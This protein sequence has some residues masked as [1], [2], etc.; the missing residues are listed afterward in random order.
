MNSDLWNTAIGA[1]V[2]VSLV[3]VGAWENGRRTRK[4]EAR[5]EASKERE[6]LEAQADELV[7]AVL[8][9]RVAGNA[10]DHLWGGWAARAR[11]GF[12]AAVQGGAAYARS[13]R[14]GMP[15]W[16]AAYGETANAI[17]QWDRES[18][19]S[20]AGLAAP[21]SRLGAAVAPLL[22]RQEPGL[23]AAAEA[24]FTTAMERHG[25][26]DRMTQA[27]EAFHAALR[28]ALEP[29]PTPRRRWSLGRRMESAGS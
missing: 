27:L 6:A 21:M 18:A 2:G 26:D 14:A 19:I 20:A 17:G 28:P 12:R 8:A 22:R 4:T 16:L 9:L 5:K 7:A 29:P 1:I 25:D 13:S 3:F 11:V 10:H 23:A 24:V 15:A